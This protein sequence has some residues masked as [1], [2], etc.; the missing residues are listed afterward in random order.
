MQLRRRAE[1]D[2]DA[3]E[4][5]QPRFVR[6][7]EGADAAA[8][9]AEDDGHVVGFANVEFRPRLTDVRPYAKFMNLVVVP[10]ARGRGIGRGLVDA[11]EAAARSRQCEFV[12]LETAHDRVEAKALYESAGYEND[13]VTFTKSLDESAR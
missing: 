2:G 9:V 8:F 5:L 10:E 13:S 7:L 12:T 4:S 1:I 6:Y 11:V 3:A